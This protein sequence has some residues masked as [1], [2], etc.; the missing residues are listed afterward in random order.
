[1]QKLNLAFRIALV[2]CIFLPWNATAIDRTNLNR[3]PIGNKFS[4]NYTE[5][6]LVKSLIEVTQGQLQQALDT[7]DQLLRA[8]PN[9]KLA[10]LVRGDLLMARAQ[11]LRTFG[12]DSAGSPEAIEDFREEARSRIGHYISQKASHGLPEPLWQL[13][14]NL[15]YAI[16]V[17]AAKLRLYG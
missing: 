8:A 11:Q 10:Y 3:L 5:S 6:L 7:T 9:F 14:P 15:P 1:M 13:D 17:D 2:A 12:N 4:P 16:V